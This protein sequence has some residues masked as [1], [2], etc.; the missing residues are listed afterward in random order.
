MG[1]YWGLWYFY[2]Q[3][4]LGNHEREPI[5]TTIVSMDMEVALC[6]HKVFFWLLL[7]DHLNSRNLL[8]RKRFNVP[9]VDCV[10]CSHGMEETMK[11][12]F[13]DCEFVQLCWAL[14]HFIWDLSLP[15]IDMI[16]DGKR[17]FQFDCY[18]EV[19]VLAA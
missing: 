12:L 6:K 13:F 18:L 7:N 14:L 9:S 17:H 8:R 19:V 1:I 15:V 11:H 3:A 5:G 16:E 2:F 10:M 4:S